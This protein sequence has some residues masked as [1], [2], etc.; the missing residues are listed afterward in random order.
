M[1]ATF[2]AGEGTTQKDSS[3]LLKSALRRPI[4]R[5]PCGGELLASP[6]SLQA[7]KHTTSSIR[8]AVPVQSK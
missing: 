7:R 5:F 2:P 3:T 1:N 4:W 8:F 6:A